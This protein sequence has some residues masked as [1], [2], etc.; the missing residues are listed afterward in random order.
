MVDRDENSPKDALLG[1]AREAF[2]RKGTWP[3]RQ[4][5]EAVLDQDHYLDLEEILESAP[6]S[7]V[8]STGTQESSEV[9]LTVAGLAAAGAERDVRRFVEALRW[10]VEAQL[11][12]R[13]T[14]PDVSEE[15]KIDADQ[16]ESEWVS[17][18]EEVS[19]TDLVKLRAMFVT[20]GIYSSIG[21]EGK[22][23]TITLNRPRVLPYRDMRSVEDY[24]AVKAIS[25][26]AVLGPEFREPQPSKTKSPPG[27][28]FPSS[29]FEE[30]PAKLTEACGILL[31]QG[32]FAPAVLEAIKVMTDVLQDASELDLDGEKL[33]GRAFNLKEPLIVVGDLSTLTGR[34]RQRGLMLI[35]Q[36]IY[37]A[38][39]NPLAHRRVVVPPV[40]ARRVIA[41]IGFVVEA[42][43]LAGR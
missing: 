27:M 17:R 33:A 29:G 40:E 19:T 2:D 39:R 22:K 4:Y 43:E 1:V 9:I 31:A 34:D 21:G 24:L 25:V 18:G 30:L 32:H 23:W 38:V 5:V 10:C 14:D 6:R 26:P 37:A 15:V 11:G 13:P 7:L 41:M 42:V 35:A 20:E 8:Y 3:I 16:F 12:F 36:G 28:V